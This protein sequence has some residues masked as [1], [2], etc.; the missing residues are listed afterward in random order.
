MK[1]S[2]KVQQMSPSGIRE[3]FDLV[4]GMKDVISLGVGEPDFSTPWNICESSIFS[5]ERGWTSYTSNKGLYELRLAIA[6][7]IKDRFS[8]SYDPEDEILITTGTSE[9]LDLAARAVLNNGDKVLIQNPAYVSYQPV[10][11]LAGGKPIL[12]DTKEEDGFKLT[13]GLIKRHISKG[14]KAIILNYPSNPTG[15]SYSKKELTALAKVFVE[16][17]ILVISD[18][19]YDELTYDFLHTPINTLKG[20]KSRTIYLNGFSKSFA[21]TGWRIG[22]ACGPKEIISAMTKVHQYT[23]LCAPIMGQIGALEALKG[24]NRFVLE[25]KREYKRRREFVVNRLNEIGLFCPTPEGAFYVFPSI[26]RTGMDSAGFAKELLKKE[27]VAV[28]PGTA[29]GSQ[30]EG[31]IRISYAYSMENLKEAMVRIEYFSRK[32]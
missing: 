5:I 27:K 32:I 13:P 7:D 11:F 19:I 23:M 28:V 15:V 4:I 30:G 17:D 9:G 8:V 12:I 6:N 10:S 2:N 22:Y 20:M 31:H 3:F 26:R 24:S 21:M 18:E 1:I 25:M 29:F 16:N 14:V